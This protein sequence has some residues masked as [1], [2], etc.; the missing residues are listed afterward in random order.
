MNKLVNWKFSFLVSKSIEYYESQ[1]IWVFSDNVTVFSLCSP[2]TIS[3]SRIKLYDAAMK[4]LGHPR[5]FFNYKEIEK[6]L[7]FI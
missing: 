2:R 6:T 5:I 4:H 7:D 3:L 1:K